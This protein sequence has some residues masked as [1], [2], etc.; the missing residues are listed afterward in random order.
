MPT[1]FS[2]LCHYSVLEKSQYSLKIFMC[3]LM[4]MGP[5]LSQLSIWHSLYFISAPCC[6]KHSFKNLAHHH[7]S[8]TF[9]P[10]ITTLAQDF[11]KTHQNVCSFLYSYFYVL[12]SLKHILLSKIIYLINSV[13]FPGMYMYWAK[14][15]CSLKFH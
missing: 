5:Q 10:Q 7:L 2:P 8:L 11:V 15:Q 9:L 3:T 13:S 1:C 6:C 4:L 14:Y 12:L